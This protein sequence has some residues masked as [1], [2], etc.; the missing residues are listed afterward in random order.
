M[1]S[2]MKG[3]KRQQIILAFTP[4]TGLLTL[5]VALSLLSSLTSILAMYILVQQNP[6]SVNIFLPWKNGKK[7]QSV[8][9]ERIANGNLPLQS[10]LISEIRAQQ[11]LPEDDYDTLTKW[12]EE[13]IEWTVVPVDHGR[14][15]DGTLAVVP[16][17]AKG[18]GQMGESFEQAAVSMKFI[19]LYGVG[20]KVPALFH[21]KIEGV[22]L[23]THGI[24][25]NDYD[26]TQSVPN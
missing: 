18:S 3:D 7:L 13:H 17:V 10:I 15:I 5:L 4:V 22:P 14:S 20:G 6:G 12:V 1:T 25:T 21:Y 9:E 26:G 23:V 8:T 24:F 2:Q 19:V 16:V 11:I